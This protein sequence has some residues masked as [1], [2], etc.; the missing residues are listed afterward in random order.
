MPNPL[1]QLAALGQSI[2]LD[3]ISR[4]MFASGQ[5]RRLIQEDAL[6]GMTSNPAIFEKAID[7][8]HAYDEQI[9]QL[10]SEGRSANDIYEAISQDDVR[11]VADELRPVYDRTRGVDGYVSLEVNPHLARDTDGTIAEGRRLWTALDR[12]NVYIKVPATREGLPAIQ[13]LTCEGINVNVTLLFGLP[14]YHEVMDA[15]LKGLEQR[16]GAGGSVAAISSVASFFVSRID[17]LVDSLLEKQADGPQSAAALAARGKVAI[18]CAKLAHEMHRHMFAHERF[19]TLAARGARP[20]R[21]LWASTS[22]KNPRYSDVMYVE[23]LASAGT[24]NTMPLETL[25][26][27]RDH[28][29]PQLRLAQ[30]LDQA[31]RLFESLPELSIDID[32]V[33]RQLEQEA[34]EKFNQPFDKLLEHIGSK[35]GRPGS[36]AATPAA[37]GSS[38]AV[39]ANTFTATG[40]SRP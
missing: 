8:G 1:Q 31:R 4:E 30:D 22:T 6:T 36:G 13:Q 40:S 5:L 33:T 34:I 14:R 21:L 39:S 32:A 29:H 25:D 23:A 24:I 35:T 2:W 16:V 38:P 10:A 17:T 27:Y 28:G 26:A 7:H 18:A 9:A 37:R 19:K 20:Q 15:Y 3:Y 11:H 12:P